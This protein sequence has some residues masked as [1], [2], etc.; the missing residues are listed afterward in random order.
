M[1][2]GFGSY[3]EEVAPLDFICLD[4][5]LKDAPPERYEGSRS[6]DE[7]PAG[8]PSADLREGRCQKACI[9]DAGDGPRDD[10]A[11]DFDDE[12]SFDGHRYPCLW[13]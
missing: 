2:W 12:T 11:L 7:A 9:E 8:E 4:M 1:D 13:R 6:P 5:R 3:D 10:P